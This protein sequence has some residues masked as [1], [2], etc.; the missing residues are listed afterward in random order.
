M[1]LALALCAAA[2]LVGMA[3]IDTGTLWHYNQ[4]NVIGT[5]SYFNRRNLVTLGPSFN[6][7]STSS[8]TPVAAAGSAAY[9]LCWGD[10]ATLLYVNGFCNNTIIALNDVALG[11]DGAGFAA[12][13]TMY[14]SAAGANVAF[15][16]TLAGTPSEAVLHNSNVI[17]W[18]GSGTGNYY[19]NAGAMV[20]G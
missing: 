14:I 20:R 8:T 1:R 2:T 12:G 18:V 16:A 17:I 7:A 19:G 5:L 11:L 9:F 15:S 13:Q 4:S 10:E 6:G 3:R